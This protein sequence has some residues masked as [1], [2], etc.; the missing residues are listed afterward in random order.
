MARQSNPVDESTPAG[1]VAAQLRKAR[2]KLG[3]TLVELSADSGVPFNT[4]A[5]WERG[6]IPLGRLDKSAAVY[7]C[8]VEIR[9][10]PL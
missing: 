7:G 10:R 8:A 5:A 2:K 9:L 6:K 4:L 1:Q 3:K